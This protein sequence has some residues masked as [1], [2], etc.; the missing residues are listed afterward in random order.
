MMRHL[1]SLAAALLL[2]APGHADTRPEPGETSIFGN[3]N[4]KS[5][6]YDDCEFGGT[7]W[8]APGEEDGLHACELTAR[9]YC[10]AFNLEWV[11]RQSCTA[12][13]SG[14]RLTITSQIEEFLVGEPTPRYWPDN[15][16]L[17]I[18]SPDRMTGSL[19]S[20]GTHATEFVRDAGG[21]S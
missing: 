18:R 20:H 6:T 11:V 14:Q 1:A 17:T 4:F 15:F 13:Q 21:V 10:P 19:V 8:F 7:A 3:W 2:T 9:Q 16:V 12:R 5:W